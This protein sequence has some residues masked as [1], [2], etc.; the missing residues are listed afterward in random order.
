ML[1]PTVLI[2]VPSPHP[3]GT[4]PAAAASARRRARRTAA[5][6]HQEAGSAATRRLRAAAEAAGVRELEIGEA[7]SRSV[8]GRQQVRLPV[9]GIIGS[10]E[11]ASVLETIAAA[12]LLV[13]VDEL[14]VSWSEGQVRLSFVALTWLRG[15]DG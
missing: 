4:L 10:D 13:Q 6:V 15:A 3:V 2:A 7:A 12:D 1:K 9:S 5:R 14:E 8:N 11:L